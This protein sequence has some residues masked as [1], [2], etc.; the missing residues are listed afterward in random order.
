MEDVEQLKQ[1]IASLKLTVESLKSMMSKDSP[2]LEIPE[3]RPSEDDGPSEYENLLN[4]HL[5]IEEKKSLKKVL[6]NK[7]KLRELLA[8]KKSIQLKDIINLP[9]KT[10]T[11]KDAKPGDWPLELVLVRHGQSEGNEAVLRSSMGDESAYTPEFKS[12]HSSMYRLTTKGIEQAIIAGEWI[13]KNIGETFDRYYTSE[14]VRAMETSTLLGLPDAKWFTEIVLRERD[15][16]I[17]DNKSYEEKK[18]LFSD[19]M[20]RRKRDAFFWSPP[21]GESLADVCIR[22]EHT[23]NTLRREC[24]NQRVIIVCHGEVMWAFRVRLER[25]SQLRFHQLRASKDLKDQIHNTQVLHYTRIHPVTGQVYPYFRFMRSTCPWD[26]EGS[27]DSW[28]EF[29][30]PIFSNDELYEIVN[31]VPRYVDNVPGIHTEKE[32]T[33]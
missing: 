8:Q 30:R 19:E 27:Y 16:G 26:E 9:I 21:G 11:H 13:R 6:I 10:P 14:Y 1:E 17:L 3:T 12:K 31:N 32:I 22:V 29:E 28:M 18:M 2:T 4:D 15:K 23:F 20:E 25:L 7:Q 33:Y 24:S 5:S